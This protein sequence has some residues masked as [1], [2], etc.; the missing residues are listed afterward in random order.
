M[1]GHRR[2]FIINMKVRKSKGGRPKIELVKKQKELAV[3]YVKVSGFWRQALADYLGISKPTL[4]QILKKDEGFLTVLKAAD[5][6]FRKEIIE[7]AKVKRPDFILKTKY[8]EEFPE[9]VEV[10]HSVD[11]RLEEFLDRQSRRLK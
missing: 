2:F 7:L 9:K 5:A 6:E 4:L 1:I 11:K 8:R 10:E 3:Q